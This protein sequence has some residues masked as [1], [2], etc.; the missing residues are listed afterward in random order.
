MF[1]SILQC[2]LVDE[3]VFQFTGC[4]VCNIT[5]LM[6]PCPN[7]TTIFDGITD[8]NS[9]DKIKDKI[10]ER[11]AQSTYCSAEKS[12]CF[13]DYDDGIVPP[14]NGV[15]STNFPTTLLLV[16]EAVTSAP[17]PSPDD[18]ATNTEDD[19]APTGPPDTLVPTIAPIPPTEVPTD[20]T[21]PEPTPEPTP[22][23]TPEEQPDP[24][25]AGGGEGGGG[26][27]GFD[28]NEI[29]SD[30]FDPNDLFG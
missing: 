8:L 30:G 26:S 19:I 14:V 2:Y 7:D 4:E 28:M 22:D 18:T 23:P 11:T 16:T 29:G 20:P 24:P 12:F 6:E 10:L 5:G 15:D 21:T 3:Q 25:D 17:S 9:F 13:Y 27:D 1:L